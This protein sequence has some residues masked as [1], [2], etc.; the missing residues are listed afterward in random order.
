MRAAGLRMRRALSACAVSAG[1]CH[2]AGYKGG[3]AGARGACA[4][5]AA[6]LQRR[7]GGRGSLDGG[8]E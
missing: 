4:V 5:R 6:G 8:G 2:G 3:R 7:S 1:R